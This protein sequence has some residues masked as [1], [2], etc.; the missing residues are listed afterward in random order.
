M[1]IATYI[2]YGTEGDT[3]KFGESQGSGP[4]FGT[5]S[6]NFS[7]EIELGRNRSVPESELTAVFRPSRLRQDSWHNTAR[8]RSAGNTLFGSTPDSQPVQNLAPTSGEARLREP[9]SLLWLVPDECQ[10][11]DD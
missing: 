2:G 5:N 8:D 1:E 7:S 9:L 6:Q 3:R 11:D 4:P 10:D